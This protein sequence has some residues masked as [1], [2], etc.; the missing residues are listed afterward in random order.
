VTIRQPGLAGSTLLLLSGVLSV[1]VP[2][3]V[4]RQRA[5]VTSASGTSNGTGT[6]TS[7]PAA[8]D[9]PATDKAAKDPKPA[10]DKGVFT[11]AGTVAQLVPGVPKPMVVTVTNPNS[12]DIQ[13]LTI[14]ATAGSTGKANCPASAL[15]VAPYSY[16]S[17][18]GVLAPGKGSTTLTLSV[19]LADSA[20]TNTTDCPGTSFPLTFDGTAE[21]AKP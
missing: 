3:A 7:S 18:P 8:G 9:K 4:M 16:S 15:S 17:G 2:A 10:N 20:V 6:V 5:S 11:I 12:W 1:A 19:L 21:K 13:V 14:S